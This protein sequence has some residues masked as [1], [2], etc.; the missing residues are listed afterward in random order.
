MTRPIRSM[1][2]GVT[3]YINSAAA[4]N[5]PSASAQVR[6]ESVSRDVDPRPDCPGRSASPQD[7][8]REKKNTTR[9]RERDRERE[10]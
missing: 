7:E 4:E 2:A 6:A 8:S 3:E 10:R 5:A 1:D 9:E